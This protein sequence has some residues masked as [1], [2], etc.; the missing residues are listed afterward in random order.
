MNRHDSYQVFC[1]TRSKRLSYFMKDQYQ[2]GRCGKSQIRLS[3]FWR[4]FASFF[5]IIVRLCGLA[6]LL[7]N[8]GRINIRNI[9]SEPCLPLFLRDLDKTAENMRA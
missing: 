3:R 1:P 4:K 6:V 9:S 5:E 2:V 7:L 8:H